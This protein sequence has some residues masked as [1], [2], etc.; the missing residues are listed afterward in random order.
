VS[1]V[2]T[3][4]VL[5]GLETLAHLAHAAATLELPLTV[6]DSPRYPYRG[7]LIDS[8][9]HFLPVATIKDTLDAMSLT[10]L[11]VLHWHLTDTTSFPV[12]SRVFPS[13]SSKGAFHPALVYTQD[14]LSAVVGYARDRGVR[15]VPEFD[16]PGHSS[17]GKGM[18]GLTID[19][20]GGVLDPTQ[21]A[22]Y[23][24]LGAFLHEM[25]AVFHDPYLALGGDEV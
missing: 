5:R 21:N 12:V 18:P 6:A 9:R 3:V 19:V 2:E 25:G 16:M 8:A 4:G 11:N 23:M 17:W 24:F 15:I 10:K 7:L 20:C 13:L 1:A 14:D 22:T